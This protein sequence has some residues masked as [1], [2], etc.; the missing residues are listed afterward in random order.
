MNK[1]ELD[2]EKTYR[3]PLLYSIDCLFFL[4]KGGIIAQK[5]ININ[6]I[7]S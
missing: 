3:G 2:I 7:N 6:A 5:N 4:E 1:T